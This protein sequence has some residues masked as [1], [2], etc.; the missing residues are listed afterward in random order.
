VLRLSAPAA[1]V[2]ATPEELPRLAAAMRRRVRQD[3]WPR[4]DPRPAGRFL[5]T[6]LVHREL[7]GKHRLDRLLMVVEPG[8]QW[9]AGSE[10]LHCEEGFPGGCALVG[11]P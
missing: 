9:L 10:V 4:T 11:L 6:A 8:G 1:R 5:V 3:S 7:S 2:I